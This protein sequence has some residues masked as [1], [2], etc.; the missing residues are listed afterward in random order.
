MANTTVSGMPPEHP[1]HGDRRYP[2][3]IAVIILV[4]W[5]SLRWPAEQVVAL[6]LVLFPAAS[7]AGRRP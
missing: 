4:G 3:P 1:L 2:V 6:L 5:L 7:A